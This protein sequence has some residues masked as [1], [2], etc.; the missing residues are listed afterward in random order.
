MDWIEDF[1]NDRIAAG[2][3]TIVASQFTGF[4]DAL[5]DRLTKKKIG[6]YTLTGKTSDREREFIKTNFQKETGEMVVLLNTKAG[7][8][9]LTLDLA[10]DVVICDQTWIPDDQQ[11]V[12]DRAHRISRN[13]NVTIWYLA[14]IGSIDEDVAVTNST[15]E[16]SARSVLDK[17]RGVEY[18]RKLIDA[19]RKRAAA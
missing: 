8:V 2:T 18:V 7:G 10:D 9:S 12:E 13:H 1:I 4:I 16:M 5:S 11:Q 6:H 19:T 14:S 15:R 17:Q 3:K